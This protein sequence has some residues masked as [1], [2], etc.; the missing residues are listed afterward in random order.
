MNVLNS[1][2]LS[3][4]DLITSILSSFY[5]VDYGYIN[6]VNPDKTI[7]VT[8]SAKL[9]TVEGK[10]LAET[11][12]KNIEVLTLSGGGFSVNWDY[13]AGDR[14]LLLGLKNYVGQ[15]DDVSQAEVP[16]VFLHYTRE[17]IKAIPLCIF[18]S[19]ADAKIEI[20]NGK[21]TISTKDNIVVNS[22]KK[23]ELNGSSK[24]FVTYAELN[25]ALQELWGKI[26]AHTHEVS[27]TGSATAQTGTAAPSTTLATVVLDISASK[28]TSIVTGG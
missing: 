4:R 1:L 15:V 18:N 24:Q 26:Q 23:I 20:D 16:K 3:E 14:V 12:T 17:T 19:D 2:N 27:T 6:K 25:N 8:H 13:K 22:D 10:E 5:I 9:V 7:N 21:M 28:T 11:T